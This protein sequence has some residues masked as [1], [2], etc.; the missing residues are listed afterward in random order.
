VPRSS[1]IGALS[2][3]GVRRGFGW[4]FVNVPDRAARAFSS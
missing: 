2:Q 1:R 3:P 4:T